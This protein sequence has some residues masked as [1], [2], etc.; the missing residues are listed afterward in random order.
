M[1][2]ESGVTLDDLLGQTAASASSVGLTT[3]GTYSYSALMANV[4]NLSYSNLQTFESCPRRFELTKLTASLEPQHRETNADFVYGHAVAAGVQH[5]L[6]FHDRDE[7]LKHLVFAWNSDLLLT[8]ARINYAGKSVGGD[9]SI[10]KAITA[11]EIFISIAPSL[12]ADW[13]VAYLQGRPAIELSFRIDLENGYFYYGHVDLILQNTTTNELMVL[14]LKTSG[15]TSIDESSYKN[16]PQALGYT[17]VLDSIAQNLQLSASFYVLYLIYKSK[18]RE[19]VP[20]TFTKT[21]LDRA[22]WI[23]TLLI[24]CN[25]ID[26]YRRMNFFPKRHQGCN[27]YF[28]RCPHFDT[29]TMSNKAQSQFSSLEEINYPSEEILPEFNYTISQLIDHQRELLGHSQP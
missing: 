8:N 13:T 3:T 5:Y 20:L 24:Q 10:W 22:N 28:R 14:E 26:S 15:G 25:E 4:A 11:L 12:L 29:C 6:A 23:R 27:A 9:K 2:Y 19:F 16:S 7:A 1:A 21:F 18:T 17:L